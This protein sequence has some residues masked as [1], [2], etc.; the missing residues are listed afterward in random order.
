MSVTPLAAVWDLDFILQAADFHGKILIVGVGQIKQA[1][2]MVKVD[3]IVSAGNT[4]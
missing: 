1:I 4:L 2:A 3:L